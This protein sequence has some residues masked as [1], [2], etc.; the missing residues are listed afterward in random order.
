MLLD[1]LF[2]TAVGVLVAWCGSKRDPRD[3]LRRVTALRP[4]LGHGC[5]GPQ[6]KVSDAEWNEIIADLTDLIDLDHDLE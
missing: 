6:K 4:R 5:S 1:L 3:E 2:I